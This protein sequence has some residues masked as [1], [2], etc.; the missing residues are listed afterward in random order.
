MLTVILQVLLAGHD[1]S[2]ELS[3]V[4]RRTSFFSFLLFFIMPEDT[5]GKGLQKKIRK[6]R[7]S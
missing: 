7:S 5:G 1:R 3:K 4:V 2:I 6:S